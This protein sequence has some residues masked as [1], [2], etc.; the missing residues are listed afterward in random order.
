MSDVNSWRGRYVIDSDG[1]KIGKLE[2]IYPDKTGNPEWA[3]VDTGLLGTMS[4]FVPLAG[5]T[6]AG[7][8]I[9]VPF[10]KEQV[11]DA[12]GVRRDGA[13]SQSEEAQLYSHYGLR[14]RS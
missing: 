11:K 2:E 3:I 5:A 6:P 7:D 9:Q 10:S 12:P 4:S 13:L 8:D 14:G 1:D